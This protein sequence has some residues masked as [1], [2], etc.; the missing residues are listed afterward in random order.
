M[1]KYLILSA[2]LSG[3]G[4]GPTPS[5]CPVVSTATP[6]PPFVVQEGTAWITARSGTVLPVKTM[7]RVRVET[8]NVE[9]L[10]DGEWFPVKN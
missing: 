1:F 3:C 10:M 8:G 7:F 9:Y 4:T 5:M 2:F 6:T